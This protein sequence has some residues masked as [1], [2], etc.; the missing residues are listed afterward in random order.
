MSRVKRRKKKMENLFYFSIISLLN[1]NKISNFDKKRFKGMIC[2]K[3]YIILKIIRTISQLKATKK[4]EKK[5]YFPW[6][7]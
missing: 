2:I 7:P 3:Q 4:E 1:D 6:Y 5:M